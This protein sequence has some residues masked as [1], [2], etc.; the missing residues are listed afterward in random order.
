MHETLNNVVSEIPAEVTKSA[1]LKWRKG[2]KFKGDDDD[3][4]DGFDQPGAGESNE[5]MGHSLEDI[6]ESSRNQLAVEKLKPKPSTPTPRKEIDP[7]YHY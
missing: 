6:I 2:R 7:T 4:D 3:D 1:L 5:A